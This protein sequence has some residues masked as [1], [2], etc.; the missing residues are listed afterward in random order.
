[1]QRQ[2]ALTA[3]RAVVMA[4]FA[5]AVLA[6]GCRSAVGSLIGGHMCFMRSCTQRF[7]LFARN[8]ATDDVFSELI[9]V[10]CAPAVR[11]GIWKGG[12]IEVSRSHCAD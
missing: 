11:N 3:G 5:A 8:P 2:D 4:V 1:M 12:S 7:G 9:A 10:V 6:D